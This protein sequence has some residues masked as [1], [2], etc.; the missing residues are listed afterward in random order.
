MANQA[1]M[2]SLERL[3]RFLWELEH[4]RVQ[5]MKEIE[6]L[7]LEL[8]RLR[9]WLE[10]DALGYWTDELTRARR[11]YVDAQKTLSR[12][13]S[14]VRAS[15]Q[16]TCTEEKKRLL[17]SKLRLEVCEAKLK[18]VKAATGQWEREQAKNQAR[19]ER[20]RD[21]ADAELLVAIHYLRGQCERLKVYAN[22]RSGALSKTSTVSPSPDLSEPTSAAEAEDTTLNES[23]TIWQVLRSALP[24]LGMRSAFRLPMFRKCGRMKRGGLFFSST[25]PRLA[26]QSTS[27][28]PR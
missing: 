4:F 26:Q 14:Y 18:T 16:R 3:E 10:V 17:K 22:L 1:D 6:A 9:N 8:R 23:A 20:C 15:E 21:M 11:V 2:R 27:L 13:M 25:Q 24:N 5:L 12:C 28:S 19:I 7:D